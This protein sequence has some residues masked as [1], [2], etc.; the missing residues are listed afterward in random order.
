MSGVGGADAV[1]HAAGVSSPDL[2]QS[3]KRTGYYGACDARRA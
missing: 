3:G 2:V 1:Q